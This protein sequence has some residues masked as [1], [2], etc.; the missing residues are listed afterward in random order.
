MPAGK[1]VQAFNYTSRHMVTHV[2][3]SRDTA[4]RKRIRWLVLAVS[5][6]YYLDFTALLTLL[7]PQSA[8]AVSIWPQHYSL[9]ELEPA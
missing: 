6:Q 2:V 5:S 1:G 4:G 8:S 9:S 3:V 7:N